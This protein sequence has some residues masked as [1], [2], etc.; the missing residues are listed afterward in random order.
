MKRIILVAAGTL[1]TAL[2][3]NA[4]TVTLYE[5]G[6]NVDGT[7]TTDY[8]PAPP[9]SGPGVN[10]AG[11]NMTTGLGTV[12]VTR[13]PGTHDVIF[14]LN[15]DIDPLFDNE[16]GASVAAPFA[17]QSWEIDDPGYPG[18][19]PGGYGDIFANFLAGSLD[20]ANGL[21]GPTDDVSMAMGWNFTVPAGETG[22]VTFLL[23]LVQPTSGFY[24][25]QRDVNS[26]DY[27]YFSGTV[28]I[29]GGPQVPEPGSLLLLGTSLLGLA[30]ARRRNRAAG[31]TN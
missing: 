17:G 22:T 13:G 18:G 14:Y 28:R 9:V 16:T 19:P 15:S 24:L 1:L 29:S 20:N 31:N 2:Q 27:L 8:A 4:T 5:W 21:A 11:F 26:N 7:V 25:W 6:T 10:A 3:A 23:S 30:V 12:T